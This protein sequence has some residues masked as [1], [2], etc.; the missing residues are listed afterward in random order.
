MTR[1]IVLHTFTL[2]ITL[3]PFALL[4]LGAMSSDSAIAR[5]DFGSASFANLLSNI[6]P[7]IWQALTNTLVICIPMVL[8]QIGSSIFAAYAFAYFDFKRKQLLFSMLIFS[9]LLPAVATMLP[10]F[11][12]M[13]ALGLKGSPAGILLP[14]VLFSPYA[15]VLLRERFE[16]IPRELIDQGRIDGLSTW[17]ILVS[18][19]AP[20]SRTFIGLLALI[21]FVSTWNAYLWPRLIA[22]TDFPTVTV[23]IGALQGQ[24]DSHWNLVLAATLLAVIPALTSFAI[25]GRSLVRNP[26]EEIDI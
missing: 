14:F 2:T 13:T 9:Y 20:L 6:Q 7:S 11:F 3:L 12:V 17:G 5:L 26:L 22:G 18:V 16:A 4:V 23:A 19:V 15:V 24:Y 10:L 21:T 8:L 1:K 25:A